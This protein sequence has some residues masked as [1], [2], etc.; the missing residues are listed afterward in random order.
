MS[1]FYVDNLS[2]RSLVPGDG[3]VSR[4]QSPELP[5]DPILVAPDGFR[6]NKLFYGMQHELKEI[7]EKLFDAETRSRGSACVLLWCLPGG[8]K[9]H[10]ARQYLYS[11]R[12]AFPGGIFWIR[13]RYKEEIAQDFWEIAQKVALKDVKDPRTTDYEQEKEKFIRVVKSWFE[14]REGWLLIFDGL[15]IDS[16]AD[17]TAW[18]AYLPDSKNSSIIL[19]SVNRSLAGS[20]R[21]LNPVAVKVMALA[22]K[23]ARNL[24]LRELGREH[25]SNEEL[26]KASEIVK[27]VDRLPLAIHAIGSRLRETKEPLVKYHVR[28]Y[29]GESKLR[30]PFLDIMQDLDRF[31][32]VEARNLIYLLCFFGRQTPFEM[33]HLG[34]NSLQ[35]EGVNIRARENGGRPDLNTTLGILIR[36]ALVERNDPDDAS[37]QGSHPSLINSIDVLKMHTVVQNFLCDELRSANLF[38]QWLTYAVSLFIESFSEADHRMKNYEAGGLARDYREYEVHGKR[39]MQH[40]NRNRTRWTV[41]EPVATRLEGILER[42]QNAIR[43]QTPESSQEAVYGQAG[44]LSVFD[45]TSSTSDTGPETPG[46]EASITP[47]W[48][49]K[50]QNHS[51]VDVNE[52][53]ATAEIGTLAPIPLYAL[54]DDGYRSEIDQPGKPTIPKNNQV[55]GHSTGPRNLTSHR[56]VVNMKKRRLL[57]TDGRLQLFDSKTTEPQV[58]RITAKRSNKSKLPASLTNSG[59]GAPDALTTLKTVQQ[60]KP[61]LVPSE[62]LRRVPSFAKLE[63]AS[64]SA[65]RAELYTS[66]QALPTVMARNV[67]YPPSPTLLDSYVPRSNHHTLYGRSHISGL[68]DN[69]IAIERLSMSV[70]SQAR[71]DSSNIGSPDSADQHYQ[72]NSST[73][74]LPPASDYT[75]ASYQIP[76]L[77]G[78]PTTANDLPWYG[79]EP[80]SRN[81]SGQSATGALSVTGTEPSRF[82]PA[83]SPSS[84]LSPVFSQ[85]RVMDASRFRIPQN[86]HTSNLPEAA[87]LEKATPRYVAEQDLAAL[88]HWSSLPAVPTMTTVADLD[89][90]PGSEGGPGIR[91]EGMLTRFGEHDQVPFSVSS[92]PNITRPGSAPYPTVSQMPESDGGLQHSALSLG[93]GDPGITGQVN[94]IITSTGQRR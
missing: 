1:V 85:V 57:K 4:T 22:E 43:K 42:V 16:E 3:V 86:V 58:S 54:D 88:G 7:H 83:F 45:R 27:K 20:H 15:A 74:M 21:L 80:L 35:R 62:G 14:A 38:P 18:Q 48:P 82:P 67:A 63:R 44:Q 79:S 59:T 84:G 39:I 60:K 73:S 71:I 56:T 53:W 25:P 66:R 10:L 65:T 52:P 78:A 94:N 29:E 90:R 28:P 49:C 34:I 12:D 41:L 81:G 75:L 91:I 6:E 61:P 17:K 32:H 76:G 64:Q 24:L 72:M 55:Q 89:P 19:T 8:G 33:I 77:R 40:I 50:T 93:G 92:P 31:N 36:Y 30:E 69:G 70:G 5:V 13:A 68:E 9:S 46:R 11:H 2:T 47:V 23:D 51:P 37:S 87:T 26:Q